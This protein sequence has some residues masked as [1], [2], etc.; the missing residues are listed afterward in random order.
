MLLVRKQFSQPALFF[1]G[2]SNTLSIFQLGLMGLMSAGAFLTVV[3]A[4]YLDGP[5]LYSFVTTIFSVVDLYLMP[6][7]RVNRTLKKNVQTLKGKWPIDL[8]NGQQ[9]D[10]L[11][12]LFAGIDQYLDQR[13]AIFL[14]T[15]ACY[16]NYLGEEISRGGIDRVPQHWQIDVEETR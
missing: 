8:R 2:R 6:K 15:L 4:V 14:H 13:E 1:A 16:G 3:I 9:F 7:Q 5:V 11:A 12:D 10:G